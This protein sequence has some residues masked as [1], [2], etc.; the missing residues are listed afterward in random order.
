MC[1]FPFFD[2]YYLIHC[3]TYAFNKFNCIICIESTRIEFYIHEINCVHFT[4]V[5]MV[6]SVLIRCTNENIT[7]LQ[8]QLKE[9]GNPDSTTVFKQ[10]VFT[11]CLTIVPGGRLERVKTKLRLPQYSTLHKNCKLYRLALIIR[12]ATRLVAHNHEVF[13]PGDKEDT[14]I[15]YHNPSLF[16]TLLLALQCRICHRK[17]YNL[18]VS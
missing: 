8:H 4:S 12:K 16:R 9:I 6:E 7:Q 2:I 13:T 5:V 14:R 15:V 18:L 11:L 3:A 17:A 1:Q 10:H